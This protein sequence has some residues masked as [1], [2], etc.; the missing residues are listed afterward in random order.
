MASL[1]QTLIA[2]LAAIERQQQDLTLSP[3]DQQLLD[4]AWEDVTDQLNEIDTITEWR[5]AREYLEEEGNWL[6]SAPDTPPPPSPIRFAPSPPP[7]T[8]GP[9]DPFYPPPVARSVSFHG[10]PPLSATR[11]EP[12]ANPPPVEPF[13]EPPPPPAPYYPSDE[14]VAEWNN[15]V[16]DREG[17]MYCPGCHY[18]TGYGYDGNDEV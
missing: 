15:I 5:D 4:Q 16:D 13:E 10:I 3:L 18:C 12:P 1:Y 8:F 6:D 9:G 2:E 17:C 7:I 14:E 11:Q